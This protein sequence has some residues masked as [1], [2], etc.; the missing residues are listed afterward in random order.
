MALKRELSPSPSLLN[1]TQTADE[2]K[3]SKG[4]TSAEKSELPKV[5][6]RRTKPKPEKRAQATENC[7]GRG[8]KGAWTEEQDTAL[9]ALITK[10]QGGNE[11]K[12]AW[13]EIYEGFARLFPE[14]GKT[15]N[16][17][18]MRWKT[19]IRAGDTDLTISEK[20]LFKQAVANIDGTE[21]AL[22]YA[23]RFKEL[24]G[25]D[26]N[27]SAASKLHKMFKSNQLDLNLED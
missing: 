14:N 25:R 23:W 22:A 4:E 3:S 5:K 10:D 11:V 15:L 27:K 13:N 7:D 9:H 20:L 26:L 18:Q 8:K 12:A 21:R 24:G 1:E 17:L 19:K 6:K 16:S 2:N